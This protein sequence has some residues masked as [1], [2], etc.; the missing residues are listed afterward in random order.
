[1]QEQPS[2]SAP[3]TGLQQVGKTPDRT[4]SARSRWEWVEASVWTAI[5]CCTALE[6]GVKADR[7]VQSDRQGLQTPANLWPSWAKGREA[8]KGAAGVDHDHGRSGTRD[9]CRKANLEHLSEQLRAGTYQPKPVRRTLHPQTR[10]RPRC[11]RWGSPR[12]R[13][14]SSKARSAR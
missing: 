4:A 14:A 7:L 1:M 13:T 12:F 3:T 8:N 9:M 11:V 6:Q 2:T 5:A 10:Q